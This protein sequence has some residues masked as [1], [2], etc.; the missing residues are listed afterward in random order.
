MKT[1]QKNKQRK[2]TEMVAKLK[3]EITALSS[4]KTDL[5]TFTKDEENKNSIKPLGRLEYICEFFDPNHPNHVGEA[6]TVSEPLDERVEELLKMQIRSGCKRIKELPRQA[7]I[8][9]NDVIFAHEK[10]PE[11]YRRKFRPNNNKTKNLIISVKNE[12]R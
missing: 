5:E 11:S 9:V 1:E 3:K 12:K 7:S 2:R 8:F 4:A 10:K 6:V